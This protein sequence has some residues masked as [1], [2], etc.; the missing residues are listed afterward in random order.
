MS[1]RWAASRSW[2]SKT[3]LLRARSAGLDVAHPRPAHERGDGRGRAGRLDDHPGVV[4]NAITG[5]RHRR[6]SA[7][8]KSSP[9]RS[10]RNSDTRK[11]R[12]SLYL[13]DVYFAE[14]CLRARHCGGL[15][16]PHPGRQVEADPERDARRADPLTELLRPA[17]APGEG[18][19]PPQRGPGPA[20]RPRLG[21][22]GTHRR[23]KASPLGLAPDIGRLG[24]R[25][26]PFLVR[27]LTERIVANE[28][29]EYDAFGKT[30]NARRR[31]LYEGGLRIY[32]TL[33][34]DGRPPHS[35]W[36]TSPTG[37]PSRTPTTS[38]PPTRRSCPSTTRR[39]RSGR[40]SRA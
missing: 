25:Q 1:A 7:S 14:R 17:G 23:A 16:L 28:D 20:G 22:T 3:R 4:K 31:R 30:E 2:R 26:P 36:R 10:R 24:L 37:N 40:R 6:S 27:Y 15:L 8:S 33:D 32:T 12:P 19:H 18:P 5:T 21:E 11:I 9:W 13:N 35:R 29:G 39:A 38:R 34:P